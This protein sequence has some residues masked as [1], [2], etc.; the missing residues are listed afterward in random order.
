MRK[1]NKKKI[2]VILGLL[3]CFSNSVQAEDLLTL[4]HLALTNDPTFLASEAEMRATNEVVLQAFS[5]L[6]PSAQA[7]VS[8]TGH[9]NELSFSKQ[10]YN[11]HGYSIS[12]TQPIFHPDYFSQLKQASYQKQIGI[13]NY[14]LKKQQ[15]ILRV[16]QAYF[17]LLAS[18]DDL[19]FAKSQRT[20]FAKELEQA[21]QRFEV[22]LVAIT[23][24]HEA[25][26][27]RDLALAREVSSLNTVA[28]NK[29]KLIE[30]VGMNFNGL[31]PLQ[32]EMTLQKPIP[33]DQTLWIQAALKNNL[34]LQIAQKNST[35]AKYNIFNARSNHMPTVDLQTVTDKSKAQPF[36]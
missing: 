6:L 18:L 13:I 19:Q 17:A 14:A 23:E 10:R 35:I 8:T 15:L 11:T 2:S 32:K 5:R 12:L 24:V 27:K 34:A 31:S 16:S 7:T 22:G 25:N 33:E 21:Q 1:F 4:Y 29:E 20:A 9:D 26:A 28:N 36:P 30:I 3:S